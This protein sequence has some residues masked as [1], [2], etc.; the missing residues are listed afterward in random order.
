MERTHHCGEL[1]ASN[2]GESVTLC[3]WA[4][5]V[6]D[7][8]GI[9][10]LEVRDRSGIVQ[11]VTSPDASSQVHRIAERVRPEWVVKVVGVVR[12]RPP[13]M[14]NPDLPT[15]AVEVDVTSLE[16]LNEAK[17]P[18]F[19]VA[20][21]EP[22]DEII[23]LR[24]RYIDMRRKSMRDKIEMRHRVVKAARDFFDG[25]GF[26]EIETPILWKST[27]E[28]AREFVVPSRQFPGRFF[29]LPQS[30][31]LCKQLL[32]V[33]GVEKYVQFPHCFRDEDPRADRQLEFMQ[34]DLEMSFVSEDDV[35]DLTERLFQAMWA[36]IGVEIEIPFTRLTYDDAMETY[37]IDRPDLRYDLHLV[38]LTDL[39]KETEVRA[40]SQSEAAKG[41][42]VPGGAG[43]SRKEIDDLSGVAE[44]FGAKGVL[45]YAIKEG[46]VKSPAAKFLTTEQM[47]AVNERLG[48]EEG[49]LA[50]IVAGA[51]PVV[52]G[53]LGRVRMALA[54]KLGLING[55]LW[56]FC[57][58][59]R[60]PLFEWDQEAGRYNA[61]HH[62]FTMPMA[63]DLELL[64]S[65][66]GK[67]RGYLY[68][69][70]LNGSEIGGGS[71]R[72]HRRAI[73]ERVFRAMGMSAEESHGRFGFL[74]DAFEYGTPPHGGIAPGLDRIIALMAGEE[75]EGVLNIR[76]VIAFPK[77][78]GGTCPLTGAPTAVDPEQLREVHIRAVE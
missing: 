19:Q 38:E 68:D 67:V 70:V 39:V 75:E 40:F 55:G 71:I 5:R 63:E 43:V 11:A 44:N 34:I 53:S 76:E 10:F 49:D 64:E 42:R 8:G 15:G 14:V 29:V 16:V 24:H 21:E 69:V 13:E 41:I 51:R 2:A 31:Q 61:M 27:P 33:A 74:L 37:G 66:P 4:H 1:R 20:L 30:P 46:Q 22:V 9:I 50:V 32:M 65:D 73:Q 7:I 18:P 52:L 56:K 26:W 36:A 54:K 45:P 60:F 48:L 77:T 23:R 47:G 62:P 58:V 59:H 28:G 12:E 25:E 78:V 3:G 17:T 35:M 6:R 57:W 72:I